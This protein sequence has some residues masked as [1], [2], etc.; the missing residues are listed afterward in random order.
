MDTP[1]PQIYIVI[2]TIFVKR[3]I[4]REDRFWQDV[5]KN[6]LLNVYYSIATKPQPVN[7]MARFLVPGVLVVSR[8]ATKMVSCSKG[9]KGES[10]RTKMSL[11][12]AAICDIYIPRESCT[13]ARLLQLYSYVDY[14]TLTPLD[15]TLQCRDE[16]RSL[17]RGD[18]LHPT[19]TMGTANKIYAIMG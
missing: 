8:M 18:D 6:A 13:F 9:N 3:K 4:S 2:Y 11:Q 19:K 17:C 12:V 15:E 10:G 16:E 1:L 14:Q 7:I 5:W